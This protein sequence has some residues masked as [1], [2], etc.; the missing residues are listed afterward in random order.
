MLVDR[1]HII[2]V[3]FMYDDSLLFLCKEGITV[4]PPIKDTYY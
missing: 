1:C 3:L 2:L 4:E